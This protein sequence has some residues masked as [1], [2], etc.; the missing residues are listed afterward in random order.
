MERPAGQTRRPAGWF[1]RRIRQK[2]RI[3]LQVCALDCIDTA[4]ILQIE[5]DKRRNGARDAGLRGWTCK[6]K[7]RMKCRT[8]FLHF[9]N[10]CRMHNHE[11]AVLY[12]A[13][14]IS[15]KGCILKSQRNNTVLQNAGRD[16]KEIKS[17]VTTITACAVAYLA[18]MVAMTVKGMKA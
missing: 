13:L 1:C 8:E 11:N 5:L 2:C 17:M 4:E 3:I 14:D 7:C 6:A 15:R 16:A 10:L 18:A 12:R 9:M